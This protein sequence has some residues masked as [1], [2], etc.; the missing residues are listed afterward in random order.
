MVR[1]IRISELRKLHLGTTKF[2]IGIWTVDY[3]GLV[4]ADGQAYGWGTAT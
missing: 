3:V 1:Q 2:R 4:N